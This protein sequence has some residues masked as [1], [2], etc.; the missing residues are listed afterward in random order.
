MAGMF[1]V[2]SSSPSHGDSEFD[3]VEYYHGIL[4]KDEVK[5]YQR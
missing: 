5:F 4:E 1:N 3:V 2:V